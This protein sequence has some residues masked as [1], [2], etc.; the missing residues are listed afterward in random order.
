VIVRLLGLSLS[1]CVCVWFCVCLYS[2]ARSSNFYAGMKGLSFY[3]LGALLPL[4]LFTN[5]FARSMSKDVLDSFLG[6]SGTETLLLYLVRY[7]TAVLFSLEYIAAV[8]LASL[9]HLT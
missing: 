9:G 8:P 5:L 6:S 4:L 1:I 2:A 3:L 7:Y